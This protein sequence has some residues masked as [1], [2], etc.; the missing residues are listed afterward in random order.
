MSAI[1]RPFV[2]CPLTLKPMLNKECAMV[3]KRDAGLS[4]VPPLLVFQLSQYKSLSNNTN[5][6]CE[7]MNY[8]K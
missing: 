4:I 2:K 7:M 8:L 3:A 6:Q 5:I 1:C